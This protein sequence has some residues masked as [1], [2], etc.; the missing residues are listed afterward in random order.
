MGGCSGLSAAAFPESL[1]LDARA[2]QAGRRLS[3]CAL[4]TKIPETATGAHS[5]SILLEDPTGVFR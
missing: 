5:S 4:Q 1:S 3:S 2:A